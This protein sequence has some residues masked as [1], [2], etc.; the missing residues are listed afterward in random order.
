M[1]LHNTTRF[2]EDLY[3]CMSVNSEFAHFEMRFSHR[4]LI[5][6][7]RSCLLCQEQSADFSPVDAST[8]D[9]EY[10]EI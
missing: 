8:T 4:K 2:V 3:Y 5:N 9:G 6:L 1:G 10:E 7:Y